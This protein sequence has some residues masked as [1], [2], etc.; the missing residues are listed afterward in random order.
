MSLSRER[1][2]ALG[3]EEVKMTKKVFQ[4]VFHDVEPLMAGT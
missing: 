2:A 3:L 4:I 1:V